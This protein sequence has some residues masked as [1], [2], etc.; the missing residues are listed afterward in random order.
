METER[1][2]SE[3]GFLV[4]LQIRPS[5]SDLP[6]S[7]PSSCLE[8]AREGPISKH[9]GPSLKF[10]TYTFCRGSESGRESGMQFFRQEEIL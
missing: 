3:P 2:A 4:A 1:R 10:S 6:V 9:T 5:L 8:T 7:S